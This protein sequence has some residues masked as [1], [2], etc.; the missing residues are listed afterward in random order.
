[1]LALD[2]IGNLI[3]TDI[4]TRMGTYLQRATTICIEYTCTSI[5]VRTPRRMKLQSSGTPKV[6]E[7]P[8]EWNSQGSGIED[9]S[10]QGILL[11]GELNE[12]KI[13]AGREFN[14]LGNSFI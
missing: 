11:S 10:L 5:L 6:V 9:S 7:F 2:S 3:Q 13:R 1:M 8:E 4:Q 12:L 14:L